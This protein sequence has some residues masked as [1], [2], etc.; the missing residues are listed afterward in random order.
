MNSFDDIP[1]DR[2]LSFPC[3]EGC[4][5]DVTQN[6]LNKKKWRCNNCDWTTGGDMI[7]LSAHDSGYREE[8]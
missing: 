8:K 4:G 3:P 7:K 6:I 1:E 2:E 5:G